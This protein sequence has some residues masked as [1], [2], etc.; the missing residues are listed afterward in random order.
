[1]TEEL[2]VAPGNDLVANK[3]ADLPGMQGDVTQW[4]E[5]KLRTEKQ[6]FEELSL[7]CSEAKRKKWNTR[8]LAA[9][10]KKAL[11]RVLFYEKVHD[12]CKAG[13]MLFPPVPNADVIAIRTRFTKG[14]SDWKTTN[15]YYNS[16]PLSEIE[17]EAPEKGEGEYKSP[18]MGWQLVRRYTNDKN[19]ARKEWE[20]ITDFKEAEFPLAMAK[21]EIVQAV[22][23]AMEMKIFDEIRL[24]PFTKK[25]GDPCIL[26]VVF[27]PK[28]DRRHY[29]LISWRI[30]KRDL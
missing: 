11:A 18:W 24:F 19:E 21:P 13:Y 25:R 3:A 5:E 27:N 12:A 8:A 28:E 7:A 2:T 9:A 20:Q 1:M 30:N 4:A 6:E 29:F 15:D 10:A 23:A 22:S 14:S 16:L 17:T 26:G